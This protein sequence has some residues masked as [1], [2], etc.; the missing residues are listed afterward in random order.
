[1]TRRLR[2]AGSPWR[3]LVHRSEP[4]GGSGDSYHVASDKKFGGGTG[5]DRSVEADGV[6]Y[7]ARYTEIPGTEFD[8]IVVGKWLHIEQMD[9]GYWWGDVGGV[10]IH[11]RA[12]RDGNPKHVTVH[13][14][15]RWAPAVL[16]CGYSLDWAGKSGGV[17]MTRGAL[18]DHL[19]RLEV[20]HVKPDENGVVHIDADSMAD[21]LIP[22]LRHIGVSIQEGEADG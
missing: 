10:T 16:G 18:V 15:D 2:R 3:I 7:W 21:A 9:T 17:D 22:F 13:G 1:V 20:P 11:V 6:T 4:Y 5:E 14:P 12:D 19:C 8:E